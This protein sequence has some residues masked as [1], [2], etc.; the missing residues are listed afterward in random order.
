MSDSMRWNGEFKKES[1]RRRSRHC[2]DINGLWSLGVDSHSF[3][4]PGAG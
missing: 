4:V 3:K 2:E 1:E